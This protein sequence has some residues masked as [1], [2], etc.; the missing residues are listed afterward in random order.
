M[1]TGLATARVERETARGGYPHLAVERDSTNGDPGFEHAAELVVHRRDIEFCDVAP[2]RVKIAVMVTNAGSSHSEP[3][4]ARIDAAPFGAFVPWKPIAI[5]RVPALETGESVVLQTE[6]RRIIPTPQPGRDRLPPA[7]LLTALGFDDDGSRSRSGL[8]APAG[9]QALPLSPFDILS[10]PDTYWAGNINVFVGGR[11]VERHQAKALRILPEHTNVAMF[12]VGGRE[13][14][15]YRFELMGLGPRWNAD[16]FSR[17]T[18]LTM[19]LDLK[20]GTPIELG[21][22]VPVAGH[23]MFLLGLRPPA[24]CHEANV[25]VHVTRYSTGETAV[26]EF[27]F[28]PRAAGPGCYVV[29]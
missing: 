14:D 13:A 2:G 29:K 17:Q 24:R 9:T 11:S 20:H 25:E 27:S 21:K 22:W 10:G 6:A 18:A 5:V 1:A 4:I 7:S 8:Q 12:L 28:D 3:T 15:S 16:I 26:V 23:A 19:A